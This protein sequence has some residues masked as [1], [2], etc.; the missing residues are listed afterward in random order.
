MGK[1]TITSFITLDNIVE[2]PHLWSMQFQSDDTGEVNDEALKEAD[3]LLLGRVTYDGFAAAWPSRSGDPYSDKFNAMPKYV[4][5]TS[6]DRADWNNSTIIRDDVVDRVRAL[7]EDQNLLVWGSPTL[8][9]V[10]I[11][12]DLVDDY[13][14][15]VSPI[16]RVNGKK[17]FR[18]SGEQ[19][20]LRITESKLL[21]GG[22]LA[23]RMTPA[24]A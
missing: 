24:N 17:L 3:A 2:D 15:L 1:L 5:S 19:H 6:L 18:E 14:L 16:V 12:N 13:L 21:S 23:L 10:L 11:E 4:V 7:K 22:M 8:V 9:K 20:D